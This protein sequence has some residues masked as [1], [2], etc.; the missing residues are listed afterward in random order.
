[1]ESNLLI[2]EYHRFQA[3]G[4]SL[5]LIIPLFIAIP[6]LFATLLTRSLAVGFLS[7]AVALQ[8]LLLSV[9]QGYIFIAVIGAILMFASCVYLL[10]INV[11]IE[12]RK[13]KPYLV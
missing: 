13:H 3:T 11:I 7:F 1:M 5:W 8:V 9:F 4:F 6:L 2:Q 12:H 10:A